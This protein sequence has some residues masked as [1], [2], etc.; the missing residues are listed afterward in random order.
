M[1][2]Q[3]PTSRPSSTTSISESSD[4]YFSEVFDGEEVEEQ[5]LSCALSS[6][7]SATTF[8]P[9]PMTNRFSYKVRLVL[10]L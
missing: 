9:T 8:D 7:I 4:G 6:L 2:L 5:P 3:S 1:S 10:V